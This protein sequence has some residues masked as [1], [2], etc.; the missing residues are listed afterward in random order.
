MYCSNCGNRMDVDAKFCPAC[1]ELNKNKQEVDGTKGRDEINNSDIVINKNNQYETERKEK[2][3]QALHIISWVCFGLGLLIRFELI[4]LVGYF[5]SRASIKAGGNAKAAKWA[6]LVLVILQFVVGLI[7][8][9]VGA[10]IAY[11]N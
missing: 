3:A 10:M 11:L 9:F 8:G 4:A 5:L 7:S 6:N 1:G 2:K